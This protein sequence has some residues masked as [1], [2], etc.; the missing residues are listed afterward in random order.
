MIRILIVDDEIS[1]C[2]LLRMLIDR[3]VAEE[4]VIQVCYSVQEALNIIPEFHP[5]LVMLDVEM[6]AMNG[7]DLLNRTNHAKF[8]I[9]FTTA[10][11]RYAIRAIRFSALD[12]LL[13]PIEV[14][15]LKHAIQRHVAHI[16]VHPQRKT[17]LISNL[18][19]NLRQDDRSS[20]RLAL[21]TSEGLYFVDPSEIVRCEG[22]NNYTHFYFTNRTP[23]IIAR[24]LKEYEDILSEYDFVRVHKSH[25]VNAR[26]ATHLD[27]QGLLWLRGEVCV[28]VSRRRREEVTRL[29]KEM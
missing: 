11:D 6:P 22:D 20:F 8:D 29:L 16:Q 3:Y 10:Y 26:F 23:I 1:A 25:L 24:T 7:F 21:S 12:Y 18:M 14:D 15:E 4:K 2:N 28:P 27:T 19:H 5:T 13:K 9:V 17:E